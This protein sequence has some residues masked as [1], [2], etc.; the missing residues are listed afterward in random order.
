MKRKEY[1]ELLEEMNEKPKKL[2][3][4]IEAISNEDIREGVIN[5]YVRIVK[6]SAHLKNRSMIDI[7][8]TDHVISA[9][10]FS[11]YVEIVLKQCKEY[12]L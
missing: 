8:S 6:K 11:H 4:K 3:K 5:K 10:L 9:Q 12:N 7:F 2:F 1:I